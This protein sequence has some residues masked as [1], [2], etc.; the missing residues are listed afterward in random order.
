MIAALM[1]VAATNVAGCAAM[2]P[3]FAINNSQQRGDVGPIGNPFGPAGVGK[4]ESSQAIILRTKK[5]DRSVEVEL[6]KTNQEMTDF[7]IPISPAFRDVGFGSRAPASSGMAGLDETYKER[8]QGMTDREILASLPQGVPEDLAHRAEIEQGLGLVPTDEQGPTNDH[9]YLASLD[10]IKQLYRLGRYEVGLLETDEMIRHYPTDPK[11]Y[12]MKGTLL[13][14]V[15][16]SDLALRSW[17]QSLRFDPQNA[18][19]R[20]FIERRQQKASMSR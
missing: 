15:G 14:R 4:E 10:R 11:L 20:R 9:S 8:A 13:D 16:K 1:M 19:L 7:V 18:G 3:I 2:R 5:G 17:T 12:Q 6:P